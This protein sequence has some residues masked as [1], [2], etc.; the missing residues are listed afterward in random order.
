MA[1]DTSMG[2]GSARFPQTRWSAIEAARSDD[3]AER[4]RALE[5]LIAAYWKPVYKYVRVQWNRSNEDAK[6]L[7]QEFFA[8]LIEKD[9]LESYDPAKARL[10]TFL[11]VCVDGVVQNADRAARRLKRGGD[12]VMLSL[13]FETAEHELGRSAPAPA[14]DFF[15]REWVRSLFELAIEGLKK[16]CEA[17]GKMVHFQLFERYDMDDAGER[18]PTY[19]QLAR[20]TGLATTD[21]TNY[22]A[23]ARREFRRIVLEKLREMTATEDEFRREARALLGV[24]GS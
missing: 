2:G 22:L 20:E 17:R 10:R 24:E 9:F 12:A 7:T 13:D 8:R 6:D 19:E 11:R 16:E 14:E 5:T 15:E 1:D 21:V 18:R 4:Q 3:P 23:W